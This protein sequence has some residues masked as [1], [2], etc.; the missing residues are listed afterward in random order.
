M[1]EGEILLLCSDGLFEN[2]SNQ[3]LERILQTGDLETGV[4]GLLKAVLGF[5]K[6]D[7]ISVIALQRRN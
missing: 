4:R 2:L 7:N 5:P 6:S 3:Q 1:N